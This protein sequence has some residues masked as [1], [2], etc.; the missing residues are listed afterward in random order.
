MKG[1]LAAAFATAA[2]AL[3]M[4]IIWANGRLI[5]LGA[6]FGID[7]VGDRGDGRLDYSRPSPMGETS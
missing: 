6:P 3:V 1:T 5:E 2:Y 7:G 4:P